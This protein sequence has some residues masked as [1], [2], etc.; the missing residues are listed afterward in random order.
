MIGGANNAS[1]ISHEDHT[2]CISNNTN[3]PKNVLKNYTV[4]V[5]R[6]EKNN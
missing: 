5:N 3:I 1:Y 4:I 6:L 2:V